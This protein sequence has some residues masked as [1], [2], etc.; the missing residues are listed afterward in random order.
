MEKQQLPIVLSL[1]RPDWGSNTLFNAH[2][3]SKLAIISPKLLTLY[4]LVL[5]N[6]N[7]TVDIDLDILGVKM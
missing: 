7:K 2:V 4:D 6:T 5:N 1:V 3:A